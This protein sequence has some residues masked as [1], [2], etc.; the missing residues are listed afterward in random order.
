MWVFMGVE[1]ALKSEGR[2]LREV[3][4]YIKLISTNY[5]KKKEREKKNKRK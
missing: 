4:K 3:L 5:L 1:F 2:K